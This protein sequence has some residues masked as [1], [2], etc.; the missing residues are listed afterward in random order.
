MPR[1]PNRARFASLAAVW[2]VAGSLLT[3]C[4]TTP[5]PSTP[6]NLFE[7]LP[8]TTTLTPI[9]V[10]TTAVAPPSTSA[11]NAAKAKPATG[12]PPA[13]TNARSDAG[14]APGAVGA[15]W[16]PVAGDEFNG[17]KLSTAKWGTYNSV[18][19]F[20][21][22]LRRPSAISEGGGCMT[23]T[24][25]GNTSGGMADTFSQLYGR[26]EFRART[27]LGRG[28]GSAI[29]LW[30]NS[31]NTNDGEI[32]MM[33]V[34][35]ETR[36]VANFVLHSGQGGED[37][38]GTNVPGRFDQ[39]HTFVMEW[40]P[41]SITWYV[42]GQRQYTVTAKSRIPTTPMHLAIQLDEGPMVNWIPAPDDTTPAQLKLQVDY[43]HVWSW[44]G[45]PAAPTS[46]AGNG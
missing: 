10:P 7:A 18:G 35:D 31:E 27:D 8:P 14:T 33:E 13:R 12:R 23:I 46:A 39:W 4:G 45:A 36:N 30:P 1:T 9:A 42:D 38:V 40:L 17:T 26:W 16:K 2:V 25:S 34:P 20:G 19:G 6:A 44:A 41:T 3:A 43:E 21:N 28:F 22:G 29:L 15:Q 37:Q 5:D 32:D 11:R 24:A